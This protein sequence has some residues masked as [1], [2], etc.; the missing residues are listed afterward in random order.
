MPTLSNKQHTIGK[1]MVVTGFIV[2]LL[3]ILVTLN[4]QT[5][6]HEQPSFM[7][8]ELEP[9]ASENSEY[10][11]DKYQVRIF[12]S[13]D[14]F[15]FHDCIQRGKGQSG[16]HIGNIKGTRQLIVF[17]GHRPDRIGQYV[18]YEVERGI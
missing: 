12:Q 3:T 6:N 15:V 10:G 18:T 8:L 11:I 14:R 16:F 13:T 9:T 5:N 17:C 1:L 4:T 2:L 7:T